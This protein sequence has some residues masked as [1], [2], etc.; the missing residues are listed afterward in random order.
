MDLFYLLPHQLDLDH[1]R[2]TID[3]QEFHHLVRVLR[4]RE[5]DVVAVTDGAGLTAE[6]LVESVGKRELHGSLRNQRCVQPP[7][8]Q[9]SVA[10]SLLKSPQR[11]DL[12]LEK[13]TELG[14]DEIIP[15]ITKRT[16]STPDSGKF[17]RKLER[18]SS[19]THAA[20][21][22]SRRYYLPELRQPC[23]FEKALGLK[24]YDIRLI[25]HESEESFGSFKP[26]GRR[27]LFFVGPEGGFTGEEIAVAVQSGVRPISFGS[28]VLRA[29]TAG[30]FA[31]ALVRAALLGSA[32]P[33]HYL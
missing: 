12:F 15:V 22:Q 24:G 5:G 9:V 31:V 13:A 8:T 10:M 19:I 1:E 29:E 30:L 6:L 27:V 21:R 14:I 28:S 20:A 26:A 11:F 16:V 3:G 25:A 17:Q 7:E 4:C 18:W 2:V 23:S 33:A 32:D